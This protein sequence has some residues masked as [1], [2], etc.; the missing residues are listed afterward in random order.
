MHAC[1]HE[2]LGQV[3]MSG[4]LQECNWKPRRGFHPGQGPNWCC[5]LSS[6]RLLRA[7]R[8]RQLTCWEEKCFAGAEA[9]AC[10]DVINYQ[11]QIA[12]RLWRRR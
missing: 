5:V 7:L 9:A 10:A 4:S 2:R 3:S 8:L 12:I 1:M 6:T 11:S